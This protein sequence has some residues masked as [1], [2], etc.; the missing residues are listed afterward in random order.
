MALARE[1]RGTDLLAERARRLRRG[2]DKLEA[3]LERL[4]LGTQGA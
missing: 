4:L 2:V 1:L 3:R